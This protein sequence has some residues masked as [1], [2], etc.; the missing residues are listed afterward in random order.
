VFAAG[1]G[2][3]VCT[4]RHGGGGFL[5]GGAGGGAG[6]GRGGGGARLRCAGPEIGAKIVLKATKV[7]A[8]QCR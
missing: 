3:T 6:G 2:Q 4:D 1:N 7:E 8:L 5:R